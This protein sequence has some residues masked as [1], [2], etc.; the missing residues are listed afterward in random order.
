MGPLYVQFAVSRSD[1]TRGHEKPGTPCQIIVFEDQ[2][3][4]VWRDTY[5]SLRCDET[6][7][8]VLTTD[9][10]AAGRGPL[11]ESVVIVSNVEARLGEDNGELGIIWGSA[12]CEV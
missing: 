5:R 7:Q 1:G 4:Y 12:C 3:I 10:H 11:E 9:M 6:K 2:H 8:E